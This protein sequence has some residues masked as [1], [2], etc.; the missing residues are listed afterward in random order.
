MDKDFRVWYEAYITSESWK[1]LREARLR[2]DKRKC[3]A[4]GTTENLHVHHVTYDRFTKEHLSDLVTVCKQCHSLIHRQARLKKLPLDLATKQVLGSNS[5]VRRKKPGG[6]SPSERCWCGQLIRKGH[7][8]PAG[9]GA[10][11]ALPWE[12]A[13]RDEKRA[14]G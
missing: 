9:T 6:I 13:R 3:Q 11:K 2:K 1:S 5:R 7:K 10:S 12:F 8:H 4:C 14:G